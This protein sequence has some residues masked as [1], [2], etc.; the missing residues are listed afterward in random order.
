MQSRLVS[1]GF[2]RTRLVRHGFMRTRLVRPLLMRTRLVDERHRGRR[3]HLVAPRALCSRRARHQE[4]V[5]VIG[6]VLGG[7]EEGVGTRREDA[8]LI[9]HACVLRQSLARDLAGVSHAYPSPIG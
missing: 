6:G 3:R 1:A 5:V 9:H 7:V 2:M 4:Q 8:R